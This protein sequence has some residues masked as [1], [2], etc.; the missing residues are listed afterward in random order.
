MALNFILTYKPFDFG[1]YLDSLYVVI[2]VYRVEV[3]IIISTPMR[4][5][6]KVK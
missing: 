1:R 2:L 6:V 5:K 3:I 4:L